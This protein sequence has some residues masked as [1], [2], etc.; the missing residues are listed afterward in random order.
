[1]VGSDSY[2]VTFVA[3]SQFV[4]IRWLWAVDL[5]GLEAFESRGILQH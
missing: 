2:W 5:E 3:Q 1:M 4:L